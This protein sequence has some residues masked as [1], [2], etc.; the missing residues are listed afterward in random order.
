MCPGWGAKIQG[1]GLANPLGPRPRLAW[2]TP[3]LGEKKG[4]VFFGPRV[5]IDEYPRPPELETEPFYPGVFLGNFL[6]RGP[7]KAPDQGPKEFVIF[8]GFFPERGPN[9]RKRTPIPQFYPKYSNPGPGPVDRCQRQFPCVILKG[10]CTRTRTGNSGIWIFLGY[11]GRRSAISACWGP[12]PRRK[13]TDVTRA[14]GKK[15]QGG[16]CGN[17]ALSY[18]R[19]L[20]AVEKRIKNDNYSPE[21]IYA[22]PRQS[23]GRYWMIL[24]SGWERNNSRRRPRG[25]WASR[26]LYPEPVRSADRIHRGRQSLH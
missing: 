13:F 25:C 15:T 8:W 7:G 12:C 22:I 19:K 9:S 2:E 14:L 4:K 3:C 23:P 17:K 20:Y 21:E 18:I 24:K 26:V 16:S 11:P 5:P 10:K 6:P 1:R